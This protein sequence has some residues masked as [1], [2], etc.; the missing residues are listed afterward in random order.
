[1]FPY[2]ILALQDPPSLRRWAPVFLSFAILLGMT[3]S[4]VR[5]Q[6]VAADSQ[7]DASRHNDLAAALSAATSVL[8]ADGRYATLYERWFGAAPGSDVHPF[9]PLGETAFPEPDGDLQPILDA[10]QIRFGYA[11]MGPP[12]SVEKDGEAVGWDLELAILLTDVL[13]RHYGASLEPVPVRLPGA[14]F[15]ARLFD[16]LDDDECDAVLSDLAITDQRRRRVDFSHPYLV[17]TFGLLSHC[18][19]EGAIEPSSAD[20]PETN[21]AVLRHAFLNELAERYLPDA[22][23]VYVD[24][25]LEIPTALL[26]RRAHAALLPFPAIRAYQEDHPEL[27]ASASRVGPI[28]LRGIATRKAARLDGLAHR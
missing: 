6:T 4:T 25:P 12:Y 13:A 11:M 19:D 1:M 26:D 2:R 20:R 24:D 3:G 10:G 16:A 8:V 22:G 5:A 14:P 15:P 27:C 9:P 17:V 28:A 23:K 21:V 18:T 7:P